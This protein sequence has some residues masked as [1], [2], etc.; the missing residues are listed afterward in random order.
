MCLKR[1]REREGWE[2]IRESDSEAEIENKSMMEREMGIEKS[3]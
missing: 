3:D 2:T 1:E